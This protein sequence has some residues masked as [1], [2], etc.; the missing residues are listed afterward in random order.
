MAY[1]SSSSVNLR[2]SADGSA[3]QLALGSLEL[4]VGYLDPASGE[5]V[6]DVNVLAFLAKASTSAIMSV[7]EGCCSVNVTSPR[8]ASPTESGGSANLTL[9]VSNTG[10]FP[11]GDIEAFITNGT[12]AASGPPPFPQ[13]QSMFFNGTIPAGE[14]ETISFAVPSS[15]TIQP[16]SQYT[17]QLEVG[18]LGGTGGEPF[19]V[20]DYPTTIAAV[21]G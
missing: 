7:T 1:G 6:G 4:L 10:I 21:A 20:H 11:A 12:V 13:S 8:L 9:T 18:F 15:I 16:G 3:P 5:S 14:P 19:E 2:I 17:V